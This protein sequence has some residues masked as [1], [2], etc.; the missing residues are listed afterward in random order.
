MIQNQAETNSADSEFWEYI[1]N[2]VGILSLSTC[3]NSILMWSHYADFHKGFCI[4]F[5]THNIGIPTEFIKEVIYTKDVNKNWILDFFSSSD[6]SYEQFYAEIEKAT[7]FTKYIDWAYEKEWRIKAVKGIGSYPDSA[8]C[9][10]IFGLRM[11]DVHKNKVRDILK[12][13]NIKFYQSIEGSNPF[14]I[15]IK[16]ENQ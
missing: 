13:K 14:M 10:V 4:G 3:N 12:H 8:I 11:P 6:S 5:K 2:Q 7:F 16:K 15:E 9:E 1:K